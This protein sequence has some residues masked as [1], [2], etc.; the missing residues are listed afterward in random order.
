M[1]IFNKDKMNK[2]EKY[3]TRQEAYDTI[4]EWG[5]L[6]EVKLKDEDFESLQNEIWM[7][8]S[9]YRL[10]FDPETEIF[11]YTLKKPIVKKDGS[12]TISMLKIE[13]SDMQ[14]K[15][16]TTKWKNDIDT[17]VAF[18]KAYCK[19]SENKSIEHG[20]LTRI[21]DRDMSVLNAV[22]LGFFVQAVPG[23]K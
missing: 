8:V 3:L 5:D 16:E 10:I 22:I 21:K 11:T 20:F 7:A 4:R 6:L 14:N 17:A 23:S 12:G 19:D 2:E 18:I 9:R 1:E 13:E 15:R